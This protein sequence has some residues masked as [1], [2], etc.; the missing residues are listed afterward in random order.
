MSKKSTT[1][2]QTKTRSSKRAVC[3]TCVTSKTQNQSPKRAMKRLESRKKNI[4]SLDVVVPKNKH[5]QV[6]KKEQPLSPFVLSLKKESL[7][8]KESIEETSLEPL[9]INLLTNPLPTEPLNFS[10]VQTQGDL[11]IHSEEIHYQLTQDVKTRS[12][13]L[14]TISLPT[15]EPIVTNT[16]YPGA[17]RY[18]T[19]SFQPISTEAFVAKKTPEDIFAYFDFPEEEDET[20][21]EI[22]FLP[23]E[24]LEIQ[25]PSLRIPFPAFGWQRAIASFIGLSFLFVLPL[26]AMNVVQ[27][28]RGTKTELEQ[29]GE[30]A[31]SFLSAGAQA[32]LAKNASEANIHFGRANERF[33]NAK[34]TIADLGEGTNLLLSILP[35]TQ[36]SFQTGEALVEVGKELSIAGERLSTGYETMEKELQPTPVSRLNILEAYLSSAIPHLQNAQK[37]LEKIDLEVIPKTHRSI[38]SSAQKNLPML[39]TTIDEFQQFFTLARILLGADG[40]KRYLIAFQN[41]MEIRPTGGFIGSFAEIKIHDG[42][43]EQLEVPGGGSYDLQGSLKE[44]LVAPEPLRLLSARWEFQDGN[45]FPDFPTSA[46][47]L[48]QFYQ[49]AGGP[50]VDGVLTVNAT[51]V[52]ELIGLLG[53]VEMEEYNRTITEENFIFEA[54]KIVE[55]EYDKQENTPKAFIGDIAPKLVERA[56]EKTSED[57]LSI[58]DALNKG[59]TTKDLQLY[60]ADETLQRQILDQ[61]WGGEIKWTSGDYLMIVDANLGGGKTD[62]VIEEQVD[63]AVDIGQNGKITNTVTIARTHYGIQG[64]LFTGVNNVDYLRL[65]TPKGSKLLKANGF[66]IPDESLF[67]EPEDGWTIDDDLAYSL[68]TKEIDS[69]SGTHI[70][71]EHGKT[72]FGNWVQTK[73]GT[74]STITFVYELPFTVESLMEEKNALRSLKSWMGIAHT[75]PYTLTIQKQSG[76]LDRTTTVHVHLPETLTSLWSSHTLDSAVFSNETDDL[77]AILLESL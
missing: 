14:T 67:D 69:L 24:E 74:T 11:Q 56:I 22:D 37:A 65:Y 41:N 44:N 33:Q 50:S 73:P 6:E 18:D 2:K 53:P 15:L 57:F 54:Q 25:R 60:L 29:T 46:R 21:E 61:G 38:L 71:Q 32:A 16:V 47:Q 12:G 9:H 70:T 34:N 48:M 75:Q 52:S 40:T 23:L 35:M 58:V 1:T 51:F 5:I 30:E 10:V 4:Q 45:W 3:V 17:L 77:F 76:I 39:L 49:D 55:Y 28:L 7:S 63:V 26:H 68:L 59:L 72:V 27:D 66:S 13:S 42:V 62:G 43:I 31:V 20:V 19:V 36:A 8:P 64:L